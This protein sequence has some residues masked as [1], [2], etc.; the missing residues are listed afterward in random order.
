MTERKR[1][2]RVIVVV[3]TILGRPLIR[4][5]LSALLSSGGADECVCCSRVIEPHVVVMTVHC[6]EAT[7]YKTAVRNTDR[8]KQVTGE[9][10]AEVGCECG[11]PLVLDDLRVMVCE[12]VCVHECM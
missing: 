12:H 10:K 8:Q 3:V 7:G 4:V 6:P 1:L 11:L 9:R 2:S 5:C